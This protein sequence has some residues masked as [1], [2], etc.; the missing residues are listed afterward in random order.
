MSAPSKVLYDAP[1]PK[2]RARTRLFSIVAVVLLAAFLVVRA[3][4]AR[5]PGPAQAERWGALIDPCNDQFPLV[6]QQLGEGLLNTLK[7]AS[8]TIVLAVLIGTLLAVAPTDARKWGR[9]PLAGVME[10]FRGLPVVLAIFFAAR[11]LTDM[12]VNSATCRVRTACGSSCS[13]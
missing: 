10:L 11:V 9:I 1:G 8:L 3:V 13:A 7:A 6:W 4:P 2:A 5:R 12:G